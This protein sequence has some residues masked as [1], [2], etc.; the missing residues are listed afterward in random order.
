M[1]WVTRLMSAEGQ[2]GWPGRKRRR[3]RAGPAVTPPGVTN[4]LER[5]FVALEPEAKWV[6]HIAGINAQQGKLYMRVVLDMYD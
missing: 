2:Q 3:Q 6:N 1:N 5:E 4:L